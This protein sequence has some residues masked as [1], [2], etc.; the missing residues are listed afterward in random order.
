MIAAKKK[1]NVMVAFTQISPVT[2]VIFHV[3]LALFSLACIIPFLLIISI[4]LSPESA[5]A[6]YGYQIIPKEVSF[7]GFA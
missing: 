2:N 7:E 6:A 5:L 4:S 3:I 1:K